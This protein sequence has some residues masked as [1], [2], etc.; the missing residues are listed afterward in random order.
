MKIKVLKF[1][2]T[3]VGTSQGI[4]QC[5]K[6]I[7][8]ALANF[9]AV[10]VVSA[11]SGV[12]DELI[13]LIH[14][15]QKQKPKLIKVRL[16]KLE[17]RHREILASFVDA[18]DIEEVW[19]DNFAPLFKKL[20]FILTGT[21]FVGDLT[22]K[23]YAVICSF[24]ERLSSWIVACAL[25]RA[26]IKNQ[27]VCATRLI[28]TDSQYLK[29][30]VDFRRTRK[31]CQRWL[32][33]P[34]RKGMVPVITGFMGKDTRGD[35]ALLGRG[36]SDYSAA[37]IAVSTGTDI[38]EI[39]T[40]VDGIM[41]ADPRL[42]AQA[43]PFPKIDM[44]VMAEM[45][46]TGIKVLHPKTIIPALRNKI[47]VFIKNTFNPLAPGTEIVYGGKQGLRGIVIKKAQALLQINN[48][49]MLEEIGFIH[50]CTQI[51]INHNVSIDVCVTSEVSITYSIN[52]ED[53]SPKLYKDLRKMVD[54]TVYPNIA[55][56][57]VVGCQIS[58]EAKLLARVFKAL[59][60]YP[61]YAVSI[62]AGF[63][64]I[65]LMVKDSQV[66]K[67]LKLLHRNLFTK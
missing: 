59:G 58:F 25:T 35:I 1:G 46:Y 19:E 31:A 56:V 40:D 52:Q 2:G 7:K 11:L 5:V 57:C 49:N 16:N 61:V 27:R 44:N 36:G 50:R 10:V 65:T 20:R 54:L 32:L 67:I 6:I 23:T 3:S 38:I 37:I 9:K 42:V 24:G 34:I 55:K 62:G 48:P 66:E 28:R 63:N 21:S 64:N 33:P 18:A 51:F 30:S 43:H 14:L 53:G 12:T 29:A 41:S 60:R 17:E 45:A 47:P 22:D 4:E 8:R 26:G 13:A 39:W 15:A